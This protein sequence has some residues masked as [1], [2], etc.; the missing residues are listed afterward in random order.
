MGQAFAAQYAW[1]FLEGDMFHPAENVEKMASGTPLTDQDRAA[2]MDGICD[3]AVRHTAP[4]LVLACSALTPFVRKRLDQVDRDI[5][6]VHL[7]TDHV[8]MA[9]RLAARD[10]FM[11]AGLLS[12]QYTAL[13]IPKG[14]YEFDASLPPDV[15]LS[16]MTDQLTPALKA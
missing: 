6:Y 12:S 15:I 3:A 8:D 1:P 14:A 10:H 11:P 2:W 4:T 5:I 7:K 9:A 16:Q 13:T